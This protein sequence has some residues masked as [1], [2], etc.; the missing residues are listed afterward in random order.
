MHPRSGGRYACCDLAATNLACFDA[1][2]TEARC[3]GRRYLAAIGFG[4][5]GLR[6]GYSTDEDFYR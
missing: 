4:A 1:E 2:F 6:H 3:C 5:G